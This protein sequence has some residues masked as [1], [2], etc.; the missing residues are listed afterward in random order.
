M[1]QTS[2]KPHRPSLSR[3][4]LASAQN[5][6]AV[7]EGQSLTESLAATP[8]ELRAATQAV[9]FHVM[10][11]LGLASEIKQILVQRTPS[12][13]LLD[14]LLKVS[15]ALL[16]TAMHVA[17]N[18]NLDTTGRGLPVYA[19]HTVVDQ[20]VNAIAG[21]RRLQKFKGFVNATLRRFTRERPSIL[22][23]AVQNPEAQFNYP[24][25]WIAR[26]RHAYP[27]HWQ[28]LLQAGDFPGPLTLR[29]NRRQASIEQVEQALQEMGM[30]SRRIGQAGLVMAQPKPVHEIPGFEQGWWSVQD[31]SAQRAAELLNPVD[32]ERVL[33]ACAAPGGKSAH[34][35]ELANIELLALDDDPTR[36]ER[37]GQNLERLRLPMSPN[38]L[39]CADAAAPDTW[40]DGRAFDAV[41]ADVPC[42]ASG[43]V[44]RHPDIRW[45]RRE[46][47]IS[48]TAALQG[49]IIDALWTT[50][51]PGGRMLYATCSIFPEE[52]EDQAR[53]FESRH[54]DAK[55]QPAPGQILP[56]L[57][58]GGG[59]AFDG[60]FYALFVKQA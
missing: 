4:L 11:R 31:A 23:Q 48:R 34:L 6:K 46:V 53:A 51:R 56:L 9:S 35:L 25:W 2:A 45:L 43:V 30:G 50:V 60:F 49:R 29:V 15:L 27:D 58:D 8:A 44:R 18:P 1:P 19:P 13:A 20:A 41:L 39:R 52:G 3:I 55:R 28:Q 5:V 7:Q 26:V 32:G 40:W 17:E 59:G 24:G 16:D 38:S 12:D 57:D 10:R 21:Q 14:A 22:T 54:P 47:D 37:I 33:D 42:T 36:L